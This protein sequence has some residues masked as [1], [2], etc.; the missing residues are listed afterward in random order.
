M[1]RNRVS[2]LDDPDPFGGNAVACF[3]DGQASFQLRSKD[4]F[5]CLRHPRRCFA[6]TDCEYSLET[7]EVVGSAAHPYGLPCARDGLDNR[8]VGIS[9]MESR[10]DQLPE[11]R[12]RRGAG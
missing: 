1:V 10:S 12:S 11:K 3:D 7:R 6:G 9:R 4:M 5:Q 2:G 8:M